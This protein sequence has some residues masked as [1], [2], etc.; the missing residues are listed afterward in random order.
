[1]VRPRGAGTEAISGLITRYGGLQWSSCG[2][3]TRVDLDVS[4]ES[5]APAGTYLAHVVDYKG[6][7]YPAEKIEIQKGPVKIDQAFCGGSPCPQPI[8]LV[9][10]TPTFVNLRGERLG[11]LER[12]V[13]I[14]RLGQPNREVTVRMARP[15]REGRRRPVKLTAQAGAQVATGLQLRFRFYDGAHVY[16]PL[17]LSIWAVK[18]V[19]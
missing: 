9:P 4:V 7:T 10:G 8:V 13:L 15:R 19:R 11:Q 14:D 12:G 5:W 3:A 16:A 17:E 2:V 1:M 18:T 6:T